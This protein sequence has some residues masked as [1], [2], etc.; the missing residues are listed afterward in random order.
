MW[1]YQDSLTRSRTH[2]ASTP[3]VRIHKY[4]PISISRTTQKNIL[5]LIQERIAKNILLFLFSPVKKMLKL[6]QLLPLATLFKEVS[7]LKKEDTR[8]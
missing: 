8:K 2:V 3:E 7:A 6:F 1:L 4:P 5:L